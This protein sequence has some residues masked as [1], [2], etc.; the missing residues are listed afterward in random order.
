MHR[1]LAL[2]VSVL[3]LTISHRA[4]LSGRLVWSLTST[5]QCNH[6]WPLCRSAFYQM[7]NIAQ[8]GHYMDCC[9]LEQIIHAFIASKLDF[10]NSV[11]CNLNRNV[12]SKLEKIQTS[13][14]RILMKCRSHDHITQFFMDF[15]GCQLI[16]GGIKNSG[17]RLESTHCMVT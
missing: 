8:L 6:T 3:V 4:H 1:T 7:K 15:I 11:S 12:L 5:C 10:S 9:S 2:P 16:L 17:Q 14:H 13:A